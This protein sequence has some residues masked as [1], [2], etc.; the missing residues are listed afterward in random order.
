MNPRDKD[1]MPDEAD[2]CFCRVKGYVPHVTNGTAMT[3][4]IIVWMRG[5][6]DL[7]AEECGDQAHHKRGTQ[8]GEPARAR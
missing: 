5:G 2:G 7:D 8:K 3:A 6:C 1:F 4:F